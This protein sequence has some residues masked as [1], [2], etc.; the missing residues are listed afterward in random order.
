MVVDEGRV[1]NAVEERRQTPPRLGC[2]RELAAR[3]V[4]SEYP[5]P[6]QRGMRETALFLSFFGPSIRS[7]KVTARILE[8]RCAR[9]A[10]HSPRSQRQALAHL[11]KLAPRRRVQ[12]DA[13]V[14]GVVELAS[15]DV[16]RLENHP[17]HIAPRAN[18][19]QAE[20]RQRDGLFDRLGSERVGARVE[21]TLVEGEDQER[22]IMGGGSATFRSRSQFR[23]PSL[24]A[25]ERGR[26]ME[27]RA[28]KQAARVPA[29]VRTRSYCRDRQ[30]WRR[31]ERCRRAPRR[32]GG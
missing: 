14:V 8:R 27:P 6:R 9:P 28:G 18:V 23:G 11:A 15:S 20:T 32:C 12:C 30:C 2:F 13:R 31:H 22:H 26:V 1:G 16:D 10:R 19:V 29:E 21:A 4:K 5:R 7:R 3:R 25:H 17:R 24:S